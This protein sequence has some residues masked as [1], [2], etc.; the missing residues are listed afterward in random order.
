MY[1][2][3]VLYCEIG[4]LLIDATITLARDQHNLP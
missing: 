4:H 3:L 1:F 2:W